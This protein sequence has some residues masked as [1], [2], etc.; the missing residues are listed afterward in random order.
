MLIFSRKYH[1]I[2]IQAENY[3]VK[4]WKLG[5]QGQRIWCLVSIVTIIATSPCWILHTDK[6]ASSLET[7]LLLI[8]GHYLRSWRLRAFWFKTVLTF[9]GESQ[10]KTGTPCSFKPEHNE[11]RLTHIRAFHN[12]VPYLPID[13]VISAKTKKIA[14]KR[15]M[16]LFF[17]F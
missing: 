17:P 11:F 1:A 16:P 3:S 2:A 5:S 7:L 8:V 14:T 15:K 12:V 13:S 6:R 10:F 9:T 4:F